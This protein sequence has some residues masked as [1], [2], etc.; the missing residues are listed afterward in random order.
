MSQAKQTPH[1]DYCKNLPCCEGNCNHNEMWPASQTEGYW[2][3]WLSR[4]IRRSID[5]TR[6]L[7]FVWKNE[8]GG[9]AKFEGT[10]TGIHPLPN[11]R[12]S[13][14]SSSVRHSILRPHPDSAAYARLSH[15]SE[16]TIA[17]IRASIKAIATLNHFRVTPTP[18][19]L[20]PQVP[21]DPNCLS[22]P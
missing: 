14:I 22:Q 18:P 8:L 3:T 10:V 1:L 4:G 12:K 5:N 2:V 13:A 21:R 11:C 20:R 7:G 16:V 6:V 19:T 15:S 17:R 9:R